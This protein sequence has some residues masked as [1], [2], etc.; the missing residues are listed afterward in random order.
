MI[1]VALGWSLVVVPGMPDDACLVP[2]QRVALI[3]EGM[4]EADHADAL[5]WLL[6]EALTVEALPDR[7]L[8]GS[9]ETPPRGR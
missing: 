2:T 4:S 9:A 6:S 3:R 8:S 1:L 7:G 5:A